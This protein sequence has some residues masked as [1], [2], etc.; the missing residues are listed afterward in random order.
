MRR[1]NDIAIGIACAW[2]NHRVIPFFDT[3]QLATELEKV[4]QQATILNLDRISTGARTRLLA[5][6]VRCDDRAITEQASEAARQVMKIVVSDTLRH[7]R[8][9][10]DLAVWR[11]PVPAGPYGP[12]LTIRFGSPPLWRRLGIG[13]RAWERAH[14][15]AFDNGERITDPIPRGDVVVD[16]GPLRTC[17]FFGIPTITFAR[18]YTGDSTTIYAPMRLD[19]R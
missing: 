4:W 19:S 15:A 17:L 6:G 9:A 2:A 8:A 7:G 16:H 5:A 13:V 3:T 1:R 12:L 10:Y 14:Y 11:V 18:T